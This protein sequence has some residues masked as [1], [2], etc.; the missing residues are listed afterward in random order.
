MCPAAQPRRAPASPAPAGP[1]PIR[2]RPSWEGRC[3]VGQTDGEAA[4]AVLGPA[5][6]F[7]RAGPGECPPHLRRP[8]GRGT[9]YQGYL[10]TK[11]GVGAH[12]ECLEVTPPCKTGECRPRAP[13]LTATL[14]H[15]PPPSWPWRGAH[16]PLLPCDPRHRAQ[17][18][19]PRPR[20]G[21]APAPGHTGSRARWGPDS[22]SKPPPNWCLGSSAWSLPRFSCKLLEST[23]RMGRLALSV[24]WQFLITEKPLTPVL[25]QPGGPGPPQPHRAR[26][27]LACTHARTHSTPCA[28]RLC[29]FV[30]WGGVTPWGGAGPEPA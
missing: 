26:S 8:H 9:F 24:T 14:R 28:P 29:P 25:P 20:E 30:R 2:V 13:S 21:R 27:W 4:P 3:R 10:C 16:S 11:C 18:R 5:H 6:G 23:P 7:G 22:E 19:K 1:V 12:K 17:M 15:P